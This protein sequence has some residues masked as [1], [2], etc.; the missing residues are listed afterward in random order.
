MSDFPFFW[1]GL[2]IYTLLE[3][4]SAKMSGLGA[5][6]FSEVECQKWLGAR[7]YFLTEVCG[8]HRKYA[9]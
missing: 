9:T 7:S 5:F 2:Q 1:W 6:D 8:T 4:T 3:G